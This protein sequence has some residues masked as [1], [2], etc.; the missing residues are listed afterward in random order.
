MQHIEKDTNA[1][2]SALDFLVAFINILPAT[3]LASMASMLDKIVNLDKVYATALEEEDDERCLAVCRVF[4]AVASHNVRFFAGGCMKH[5]QLG[6][7]IQ[8]VRLLLLDCIGHS[9]PSVSSWVQNFWQLF[10]RVCLAADGELEVDR[11]FVLGCFLHL[12]NTL[13]YRLVYPESPEPGWGERPYHSTSFDHSDFLQ[14]RATA[15]DLCKVA[16]RVLGP[17]E[18]FHVL[19]KAASG[20][21]DGG[22]TDSWRHAEA[23]LFAANAVSKHIVLALKTSGGNAPESSKDG[24]GVSTFLPLG[25][26]LRAG[27]SMDL[28][29]LLTKT[30]LRSIASYSTML[31]SLFSSDNGEALL[32][33]ILQILCA[34]LQ[35]RPLTLQ[36]ARSF[37]Q[38]AEQCHELLLPMLEDLVNAMI[39][40]ANTDGALWAVSGS[41]LAIVDGT[42]SVVVSTS[43]LDKMDHHIAH[44]VNT[45]EQSLS[46]LVER[47][48]SCLGGQARSAGEELQLSRIQEETEQGTAEEIR[49]LSCVVRPLHLYPEG[50][51]H[52]VVYI[53]TRTWDVVRQLLTLWRGNEEVVSA[54]AELCKHIVQTARDEAEPLV[55]TMVELLLSCYN[56][57]NFPSCLR[58]IG[59]IAIHCKF[60]VSEGG[61]GEYWGEVATAMSST[62]FQYLQGESAGRIQDESELIQSYFEFISCLLTS[63]AN[64]FPS[65]LLSSILDLAILAI[66]GCDR[67]AIRSIIAVLTALLHRRTINVDIGA[68]FDNW[69]GPPMEGS[70]M[71]LAMVLIKTLPSTFQQNLARKV[72]GFLHALFHTYPSHVEGW[73]GVGLSAHPDILFRDFDKNRVG[74]AIL[75]SLQVW[76][77]CLT[78][79][80]EEG[81]QF[82]SQ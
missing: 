74:M 75:R 76:Y 5:P 60:R 3:D 59:A 61:G 23:V 62:T 57:S 67:D 78:S 81:K 55:K 4:S 16:F 35:R 10:G 31:P 79:I 38:M 18:Y 26:C 71:R 51:P 48:E 17:D 28:H 13:I 9:S 80:Q 50:R 47:S 8:R 63:S 45:F 20:G 40:T 30:V 52:P 77:T 42:M 43:N 82:V 25:A 66:E 72:G 37:R 32:S 65:G 56:A 14:Y 49:A 68:A 54:F 34:S 11:E 22:M 1:S 41:K 6:P 39:V 7:Y 46:S 2:A 33:R 21:G 58:A 19:A 70:G 53:V 29:P 36:A 27:L 64:S 24:G 69:I 12:L 44:I 15:M 73:I